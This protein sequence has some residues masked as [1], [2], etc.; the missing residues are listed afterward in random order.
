MSQVWVL[1]SMEGDKVYFS[2]DSDSQLTK[3]LAA[4]LCEGGA[5]RGVASLVCS[6]CT[7]TPLPHHVSCGSECQARVLAADLSTGRVSGPLSCPSI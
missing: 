3:G 6:L 4:L 2:A 1:P 7:G 5:R